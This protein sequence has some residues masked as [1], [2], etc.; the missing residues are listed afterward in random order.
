MITQ[1]IDKDRKFIFRINY[2]VKQWRVES[3]GGAIEMDKMI[4]RKLWPTKSE[5]AQYK[6]Y[7][8]CMESEESME[9]GNTTEEN[10]PTEEDA[11]FTYSQG[12]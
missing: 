3:R 2:D 12:A 6:Q 10:D 7:D 1:R 4:M 9:E 5:A 8:M 11:D